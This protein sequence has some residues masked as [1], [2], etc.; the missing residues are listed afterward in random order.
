[1]AESYETWLNDVRAAL[2]S[3]NMPMTDWQ[4]VWPFNVRAEY[5][6]GTKP[7]DAAMKANR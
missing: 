4:G 5:N 1:M 2:D 6:A 3:V 7:D